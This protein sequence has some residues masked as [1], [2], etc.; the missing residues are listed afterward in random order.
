MFADA[1][2]FLAE[3]D[4]SK[5]LNLMSKIKFKSFFLKNILKKFTLII[6]Y[7][8]N[9]YEMFVS[10]RDA[11]K[12]FLDYSD[13][14]DQTIKDFWIKS[15]KDFCNCL[16]KMFRLRETKDINEIVLLKKEIIENSSDLKKWFLSKLDNVNK[17]QSKLSA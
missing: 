4:Y 8:M 3:A 10:I 6:Q 7:E 11:Y 2:I 15:S 16:D 17:S 1:I 13:W 12:H 9:D 14:G 5:S